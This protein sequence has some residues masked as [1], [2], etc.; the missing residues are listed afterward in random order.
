MSRS[1]MPGWDAGTGTRAIPFPERLPVE[2]NHWW[3][4]E[5]AE[6]NEDVFAENI[7]KASQMGFE[8]CTLDAGWFGPSDAGTFWEHYRGDWHLVN[9][10]RF[11]SGIRRLADLA[12]ARSMKFGIW[13]EIEALGS[14]ASWRRITQNMWRGVTVSV[15]LRMFR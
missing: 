1:S 6:I 3:P 14:K 2:W 10:S 7:E 9:Q 15:G 13:C 12:H 11:P 5:D 4:Y 8:V